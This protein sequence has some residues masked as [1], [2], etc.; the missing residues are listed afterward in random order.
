MM[1]A[2]GIDTSSMVEV[3]STLV[4]DG[5]SDVATAALG[6]GAFLIADDATVIGAVDDV[7]LPVVAVV[8]AVATIAA[9]ERIYSFAKDSS[10]N[11]RHGD[12]GALGKV[13]EQ[14]A[15]L[16]AQLANTTGKAA[17]KIK[18]KIKNVK[19]NA[20]KNKKGE[21]HSRNAKGN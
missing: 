20:A 3:T 16:E 15:G 13:E 8:A 5:E 14:L 6:V 19:R 17:K 21:T 12:S 1:E 18:Q 11:E 7:L 4:D 2:A 10:K 9:G